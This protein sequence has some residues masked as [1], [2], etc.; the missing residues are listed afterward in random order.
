M[1]VVASSVFQ[2]MMFTHN[3]KI[4]TIDQIKNYDPN[5][6]ANID[7]FLPLVRTISDDYL[8]IDMGLDILKDPHFLGT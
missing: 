5:H 8:V 1:K 2:M 4:V 3:E 7:S 6:S